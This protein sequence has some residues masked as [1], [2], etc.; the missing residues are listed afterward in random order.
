MSALKK[1]QNKKYLQ[2]KI[3]AVYFVEVTGTINGFPMLNLSFKLRKWA[4]TSYF[5]GNQFL[6][7]RRQKSKLILTIGNTIDTS[8]HSHK[9]KT[10]SLET[11]TV[12]IKIYLVSSKF[13][14]K[15]KTSGINFKKHIK[16]W[17]GSAA[18][19]SFSCYYG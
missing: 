17:R 19:R 7:F 15:L 6:Y 9:K 1:I 14:K 12:F 10:D 2:L 13:T 8:T 11:R 18:C 3:L 4:R 5:N 16:L